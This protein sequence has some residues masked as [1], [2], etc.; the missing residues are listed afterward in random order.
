[1]QISKRRIIITEEI[2]YLEQNGVTTALSTTRAGADASDAIRLL[3]SVLLPGELMRLARRLEQA[4]SSDKQIL[5]GVEFTH[6]HA[7]KI[8][9]HESEILE[10]E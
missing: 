5:V 10:R 3:Q 2:E 7:R 9:Y 4:K 1:M 6:G 8:V